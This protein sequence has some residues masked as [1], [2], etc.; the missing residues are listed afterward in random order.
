MKNWDKSPIRRTLKAIHFLDEWGLAEPQEHKDLINISRT[1][2]ALVPR[3]ATN[4][5]KKVL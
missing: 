5:L 1:I 3:P 4:E 2:H